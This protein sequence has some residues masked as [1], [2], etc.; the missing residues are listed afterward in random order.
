MNIFF[1]S[2]VVGFIYLVFIVNMIY[3][4]EYV[5]Y[6]FLYIFMFLMIIGELIRVINGCIIYIVIVFYVFMI[7]VF[8]F[9]FS[10]EIGDFF[11]MK[12]IVF[13]IIIV[14]VLFI[15]ISLIICVIVY[16]MMK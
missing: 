13:F 12:V 6:Y 14:G 4:V 1:V 11:L 2:I 3:G 7:F 9:L 10:E 8:V 15:I 16:K 5:G